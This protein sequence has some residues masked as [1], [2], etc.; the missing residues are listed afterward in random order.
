MSH[1]G[2]ANHKRQEHK[3]GKNASYLSAI[4]TSQ[5]SSSIQ[6]ASICY[7]KDPIPVETKSLGFLGSRLW[8]LRAH[9]PS[10]LWAFVVPMAVRA[11]TPN[12]LVPVS[13]FFLES[14]NKGSHHFTCV[15]GIIHWPS[16]TC[17]FNLYMN[18]FGTQTW[19]SNATWQAHHQIVL[20]SSY[21]IQCFPGLVAK[22][23]SLRFAYF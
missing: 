13:T 16:I 15:M 19:C 20:L 7:S 1:T 11:Y 5:E 8:M 3:K 17:H 2:Q 22:V 18:A 21:W 14:S 9:P 23:N 12:Y 4:D 10:T 6:F